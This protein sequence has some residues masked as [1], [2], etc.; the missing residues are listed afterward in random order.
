MPARETTTATMLTREHLAKLMACVDPHDRPHA[1][2]V[3]LDHW[4]VG[5]TSLYDGALGDLLHEL[6]RFGRALL[7]NPDVDVPRTITNLIRGVTA[8][9]R[10][11]I[12]VATREEENDLR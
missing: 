7:A 12:V 1:L 2:Q 8:Q 5:H 6:G 10:V 9:V 11:G 3:F 4:L